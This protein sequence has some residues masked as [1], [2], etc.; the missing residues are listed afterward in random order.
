[1]IIDRVT[2]TGADDGVEPSDLLQLHKEF[3]FVEFGILFSKER[4]GTARYPSLQ[5]IQKLRDVVLSYEMAT[6]DSVRFAAH[7][8]GGFVTDL[9]VD[10]KFTWLDFVGELMYEFDRVQLNMS[11]DLFLKVDLEA[12]AVDSTGMLIT[13]NPM[14]FYEVIIQTRR[15]FDRADEVRRINEQRGTLFE[16]L[17]DVSGGKGITPNMWCKPAERVFCGYAGGLNADNIAETISKLQSFCLPETKVWLDMESG[18]RDS[19]DKFSLSRA[20]Q[21]LSVAKGR[22]NG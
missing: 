11:D 14:P 15:P 3:P 12:L 1:M 6:D 22:L 4:Q 10:R 7:L 17:Y 20:H 2:I 18:V 5:W 8:C 21:C 16:M 13:D 19:D 9:L